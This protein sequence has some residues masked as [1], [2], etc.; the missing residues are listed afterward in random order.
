MVQSKKMGAGLALV[1]ALFGM[2]V[3]ATASALPELQVGSRLV[4]DGSTLDAQAQSIDPTQATADEEA[5][6]TA[7][8][9]AA[10]TTSN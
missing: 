3:S 10:D 2:G 6:Q 5:D 4:Q 7:S 8:D 9:A 1:A